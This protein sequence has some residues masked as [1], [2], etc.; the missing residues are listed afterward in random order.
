MKGQPTYKTE[1]IIL[2][3]CEVREYDRVY[4][5]F[6]KE[7]GKMVV[8]GIG[9][10]KPKAKLASGLEPITKSELFC[11]KGRAWDRVAGVIIDKQY[12]GIKESLEALI[13]VKKVFRILEDLLAQDEPNVEIFESLDFY[14]KNI[15]G[16]LVFKRKNSI[17]MAAL[18]VVWKTI[19]NAGY[20]PQLFQCVSC[21]K[22]LSKQDKYIFQIPE[23]VVCN[24]CKIKDNS[25]RVELLENSIKALRFIFEKKPEISSKLTVPENVATQLKYLTNNFLQQILEKKITL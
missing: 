11:V 23:G 6:S 15:D 20:E 4:T 2:R 19:C 9:T 10:R 3:S 5:I 24:S 22:R 25:N 13:E 21:S 18:S 7:K 16:D 8:L 17:S 12:R 1:A 14:L